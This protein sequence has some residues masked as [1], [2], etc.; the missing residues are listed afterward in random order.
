M[1]FRDDIKATLKKDYFMKE[2][3]K[4]EVLSTFRFILENMQRKGEIEGV[5]ESIKITQIDGRNITVEAKTSDEAH[6]RIY[7]VCLDFHLMD[8]GEIS[9]EAK[10]KSVQ[11][12]E[13]PVELK[14]GCSSVEKSQYYD[15]V[16]DYWDAEQN[17]RIAGQIDRMLAN[18]ENG[19]EQEEK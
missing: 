19:K 17:R 8:N 2:Y 5:V 6:I 1:S 7:R 12:V 18:K 13:Q 10:I 14:Q 4:G 15:G 11:K 16:E 3:N 9:R